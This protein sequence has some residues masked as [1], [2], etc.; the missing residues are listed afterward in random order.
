M[1]LQYLSN[2]FMQTSLSPVDEEDDELFLCDIVD[3]EARQL[4]RSMRIN[5]VQHLMQYQ[6]E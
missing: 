4:Y 1:A 3:E 6:I 5:C 2:S